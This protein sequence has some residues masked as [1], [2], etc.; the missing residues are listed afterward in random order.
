MIDQPGNFRPQEVSNSV[1]AMGTVGFGADPDGREGIDGMGGSTILRT[2]N[3]MGDRKLVMDAVC[4]VTKSVT[5]R[6]SVS[7]VKS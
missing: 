6:F 5:P 4:V 1:W 2:D 7:K 3:T